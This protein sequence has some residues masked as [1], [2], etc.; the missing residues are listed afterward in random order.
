VAELLLLVT[1]AGASRNLGIEERNMPLM[2]DWSDALCAALDEEEQGLAAACHLKPGMDGP[3]FEANLGLLLAFDQTRSLI[4]R[5]TALGAPNF[6]EERSAIGKARQL[7]DTRI[8]A[9]KR[10][11]DTTLYDQFGLHQVDDEKAAAAYEQLLSGNGRKEL[12]LATT[13]YDRAGEVALAALDFDIDTGFRATLGRTPRLDPVGLVE[14]RGEKTPVIHL[15]G[16]VGWYEIDGAI[17]DHYADKPYNPSLG[18]PVVL[19]PDPDKDPT[20][21]VAVSQLWGEFDQAINA[22]EV[23]VVIGHSLHDPSLVR[24]LRTASL[25]KPV[26]ISYFDK[27]GKERIESKLP[28]AMALHLDFG[29]GLKI[30]N[31]LKKVMT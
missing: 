6:R 13:N 20:K 21:D 1:G 15:H 17:E 3:E 26:V 28:K 16:A 23:V 10:A 8:A 12:A 2:S 31:A 11:I 25:K 9:L 24:A 29:P 4:D 7:T 19:Y 14:H 5:F 27:Q 22:A 18:A 30:P